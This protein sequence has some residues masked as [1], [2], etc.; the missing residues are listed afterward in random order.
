M[1]CFSVNVDGFGMLLRSSCVSSYMC[2]TICGGPVRPAKYMT[3]NDEQLNVQSIL[4][5]P[6]KELT[7]AVNVEISHSH[8]N[9][10]FSNFTTFL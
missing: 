1:P 9:I 4:L 3:L 10:H 7:S 2:V 5:M 8:V 6:Q